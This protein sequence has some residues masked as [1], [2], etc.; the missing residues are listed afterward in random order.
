M[1]SGESEVE[2]DA[3]SETE[4]T[5]R[6]ER[7]SRCH[8]SIWTEKQHIRFKKDNPCKAEPDVEDKEALWALL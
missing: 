7:E 1:E 8:P 2:G 4:D 6:G 3:E 5:V